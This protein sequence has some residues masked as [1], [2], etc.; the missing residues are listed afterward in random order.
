MIFHCHLMAPLLSKINISNIYL[1][2]YLYAPFVLIHF[3]VSSAFYISREKDKMPQET[4]KMSP[5][6]H[7]LLPEHSPSIL[8]VS[9]PPYWNVLW[10]SDCML[11]LNIGPGSVRSL[12][13]WK[14]WM[15]LGALTLLLVH[16]TILLNSENAH[17]LSSSFLSCFFQ[18]RFV[19]LF[20]CFLL[21]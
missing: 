21:V 2:I 20:L 5:F 8:I 18:L 6:L 16:P 17:M 11:K 12:Q 15:L 19:L 7:C 14:W 4:V 13:R 10:Q 9:I 1:Y 3:L